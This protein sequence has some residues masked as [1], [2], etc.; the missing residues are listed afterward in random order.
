MANWR[1]HLKTWI[2]DSVLKLRQRYQDRMW[3]NEFQRCSTAR[4]TF[5]RIYEAGYWGQSNAREEKFFSGT[6][7]HA[8]EAVASYLD[9]VNGFL[10]SLTEKPDVVDLGCGDFA[11]GSRI[12]PYCRKYVA[13]DV[14]EELLERNKQRYAN[15]NVDFRAIDI[16]NEDLPKGDVVLLRQVLQHL[17]NADI[18]K[19]AAKLPTAF[20]FLILTEHLP[21]P[22]CFVP[23][24]D[25][26]RGPGIRLSIGEEGSGIVLTEPPFNLKAAKST[27][28]CEVAE[29]F[30]GRRGIIRTTLYA[31]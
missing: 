28:L 12:R 3:R 6:G 15:D 7:S 5:S 19:V 2:P 4:E 27:R 8:S 30:A 31:F 13:V 16:I 9:A 22:K 24:L 21:K 25:K 14:V 26:P 20:R 17:S 23:N 18:E 29:D 10:R 11:I 1:A